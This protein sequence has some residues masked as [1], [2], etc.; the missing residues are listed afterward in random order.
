[1]PHPEGLAGPTADVGVCLS[2]GHLGLPVASLVG[3]EPH[4]EHVHRRVAVDDLRN[5]PGGEARTEPH[6][7]GLGLRPILLREPF[8]G[9]T[10]PREGLLDDQCDAGALHGHDR[11]GHSASELFGPNGDPL[12]DEAAPQ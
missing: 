9:D 7:C 6:R 8:V 5:P 11:R 12:G 1:M 4:H 3:Q 10:Q 2:L